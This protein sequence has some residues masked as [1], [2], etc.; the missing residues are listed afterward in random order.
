MSFLWFKR[1]PVTV[2]EK[3]QPRPT[4]ELIQGSPTVRVEC[5]PKRKRTKASKEMLN[6][7]V[8]APHYS[9]GRLDAMGKR[10]VVGKEMTYLDYMGEW[11]WYVYKLDKDT[12]KWLVKGEFVDKESA[13]EYAKGLGG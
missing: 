4:R 13:I 3:R 2:P 9:I 1:K 6:D 5:G 11:V 8:T 12:D 10:I 7:R